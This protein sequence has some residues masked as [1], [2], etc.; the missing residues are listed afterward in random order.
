MSKLMLKDAP[1]ASRTKHQDKRKLCHLTLTC[2]QSHL[3]NPYYGTTAWVQ[4]IQ[5]HPIS[6]WLILKDD[7]PYSKNHRIVNERILHGIPKKI[8]CDRGP[9]FAS[10]LMKELCTR[11][12]SQQSLSTTY[13]PQTDGQVEHLHQEMETFLC[14]YVNH[15]QDNWE[16][17]LAITK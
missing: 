5:C 1:L 12:G 3:G 10:E 16:D 17:W 13:H 6:H 15:L 14:H 8:T 2:H 9:Q 4:W 11:L 7:S